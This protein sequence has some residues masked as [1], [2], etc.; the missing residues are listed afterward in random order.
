MMLAITG[1]FWAQL[2]IMLQ[3]CLWGR[4]VPMPWLKEYYETTKQAGSWP[5]IGYNPYYVVNE[6]KNRDAQDRII[7]LVSATL[8]LTEWLSLMGR[9]GTDYYT[10][11]LERKWPVGAKGSDN[12]NGRIYNNF[13]TVKDLNADVILTAS[14]DI[15]SLQ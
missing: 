7:G 2:L 8:K 5:G 9:A 12:I 13:S 10:Q 6:L 4:Y 1:L 15:C 14:K 11:T 3:V